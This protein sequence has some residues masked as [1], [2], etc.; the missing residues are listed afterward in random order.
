MNVNVALG[1]GIAA[2]VLFYLVRA[3]SR[4]IADLGRLLLRSVVAFALIWAANVVGGFM[5]FHMGL[6]L[7]SAL[8]VGLLGVPGAGLLLAVKYLL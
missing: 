5:G 2:L 8:T 1:I 7:V 3:L 6:N 4:P